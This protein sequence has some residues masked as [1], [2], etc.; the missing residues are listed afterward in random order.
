MSSLVIS[1]LIRPIL[2]NRR[3]ISLASSLVD[4]CTSCGIPLQLQD[5]QKPGF[6]PLI[7]A[8]PYVKQEDLVYQKYI[9][10]L[11][12]QDLQLL[13]QS[14][15]AQEQSNNAEKQIVDPK[16]KEKESNSLPESAECL[17]CRRIKY[18][19]TLPTEEGISNSD[20]LDKLPFGAKI[21]H[22]INAVDFPIG[23]NKLINKDAIVVISKMDLIYHDQKQCNKFPFF[24][25]YL[26][27]LGVPPE[28]VFL[29]SNTKS[30][31]LDILFQYL[32]TNPDTYYILGDINSGKSSL[33]SKLIYLSKRDFRTGFSKWSLKNGPG[34]SS[35]PGFTR[36]ELSF[37]FGESTLVDLPGLNHLQLPDYSKFKNVFKNT[38]IYKYGTYDAKYQTFQ[39]KMLTVAGLF[40]I[41]PPP[42]TIVQYKNLINFEAFTVKNLD[43]LLQ[44]SQDFPTN[45]SL[46]TKFLIPPTTNLKTFVVPPFTGKIDLVVKNLGYI[47][48]T[49][50]GARKSSTLFE[51]MV[52]DSIDIEIRIRKPLINYI[53]KTL[54][55]RDRRGNPLN[56]TNLW[57]STKIIRLLDS[58]VFSSELYEKKGSQYDT[59][60]NNT[61]K[62]YDMNQNPEQFWVV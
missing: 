37:K 32:Y 15:D 26:E 51:I 34:I 9:S 3:Y 6:K 29:V 28:Q 5:P 39:N 22:V 60:Y 14:S 62:Q 31:G 53:S 25:Q 30:W 12:P 11:D 49:P 2:G 40:Y 7:T 59:I 47:E 46:H 35:L 8:K 52:P 33:I 55:G 42:D 23:V 1:R 18:Q 36:D 45:K 44:F 4:K 50:T 21:I 10:K 48:L 20:I 27:R 43:R 56:K 13:L 16:P 61:G 17:R 24:K 57:K 54:S 41:V 38:K 58:S 19:N